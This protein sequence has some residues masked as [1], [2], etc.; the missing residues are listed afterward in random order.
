MSGSRL[1]VPEASG[2]RNKEEVIL[3]M[4]CALSIP[5]I[6]PFG[7]FRLYQHNWLLGAIDLTLVLGMSCV[8]AFVWHSRRVRFASVVVSLFYSTG[9]LLMIH[10]KG[11]SMTYWAYP[12][13]IATFFLLRPLIA[14]AINT[15]SLFGLMALLYGQVSTLDQF[16][17]TVSIVLIN[18]FSY[19]FSKRTA[20]QHGELNRLAEQDFLTGAGNRR[21]LERSLASCAET[22]QSHGDTSLLLLDLDHFK[23]VNDHFGHAAGDL[24]LV[25]LC[26]LIRE[27]VRNSDQLFRYGGE[28]FVVIAWGASLQAAGDL[29]EDLRKLVAAT[30]ML[31]DCP[32]T[33]SIG[34]ATL[35][36]Q[37]SPASWLK[38]ADRMLYLAKQS[39][40]N[41]VRIAE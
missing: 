24:V 28:E 19:I 22:Q 12:T 17:I 36:E 33:I 2:A 29:A 11:I 7:I 1:Q 15:V 26:E 37:E 5:S 23:Q 3:L 31:E 10:L 9:M 14:L 21:A 30:V 41:A 40:R 8:M 18:L 13:M 4:L 32:L 20:I 25:R 35:R 6:L 38:R 39:G 16:T 34:V 27:R